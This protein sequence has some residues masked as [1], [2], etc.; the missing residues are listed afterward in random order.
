MAER[1]RY[2]HVPDAGETRFPPQKG[3]QRGPHEPGELDPHHPLNVPA[4]ELPETLPGQQRHTTGMGGR[5]HA[6]GE[7]VA[8]E[9]L[10]DPDEE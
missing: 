1:A 10:P 7:R 3:D 9:P 6:R 5:P 8:D 2:E 4:D